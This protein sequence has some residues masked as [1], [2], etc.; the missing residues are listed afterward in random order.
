MSFPAWNRVER[1]DPEGNEKPRRGVEIRGRVGSAGRE[2][3]NGREV[4]ISRTPGRTGVGE[5]IESRTGRTNDRYG[6][7]GVGQEL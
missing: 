5:G 7:E 4:V 2:S 3:G 1:F 6:V